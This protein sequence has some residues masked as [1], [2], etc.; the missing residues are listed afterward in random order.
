MPFNYNLDFKKTNFRLHP[1][2]YRV[3]RGEQG[4]LI[5]E[6]YKSEILPFWKFKT[7]ELAQISADEIYLLF[8]NYLQKSDFVGAD[9]ARKYLQMGFTRSRRYANHSSGQ[10]YEAT[11]KNS[12]NINDSKSYPYSSGSPNKNNPILPQNADAMI[13]QKARSA[14]IFKQKWFLAKNNAVYRDL[15]HEHKTKYGK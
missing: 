7:P 11:D 13:N 15:M 1:E 5:V 12:P 2:L 3:G 9:M 14:E 6:P 8:L 10:K 4:V